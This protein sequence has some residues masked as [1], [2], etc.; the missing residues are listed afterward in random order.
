MTETA[1]TM[2]EFLE[3]V[4]DRLA[5]DEHHTAVRLAN[6]AR[7]KLASLPISEVPEALHPFEA[8]TI[9]DEWIDAKISYEDGRALLA[10]RRAV[11]TE[12]IAA[13]GNRAAISSPDTGA[14]LAAYDAKLD[15]L[16]GAAEELVDQLNGAK[17]PDEAIDRGVAPAW[18]ALAQVADDYRSL[19]TAQLQEMPLD[20]V[21]SARTS[22]GGEDHAS[23]LF[24]RN[25]DTLWPTWRQQAPAENIIYVDGRQARRIEPWPSDPTALLVWLV[26]SGADPWIP[27]TAQLRQLWKQR[28]ARLNPAAKPISHRPDKPTSLIPAGYSQLIQTIEASPTVT[29]QGS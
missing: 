11:L 27:T 14:I 5:P 25:L 17:S 12:F 20:L 8:G 15:E 28:Q 9:T 6:E 21:V 4:R 26:T 19:R 22:V 3:G 10:K 13:A 23:D 18:K 29:N 2:Q 24:L 16:L 7:A 1:E